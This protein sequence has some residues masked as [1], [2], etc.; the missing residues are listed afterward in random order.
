M[1][2]KTSKWIKIFVESVNYIIIT[3]VVSNMAILLRQN[4]LFIP[5]FA[6]E[7]WV[8]EKYWQRFIRQ[9]EARLLPHVFVRYILLV[10][11]R[12]YCPN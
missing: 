6:S 3:Y 10:Y 12:K 4:W 8:T 9:P 1:K 2:T 5:L 11:C 7:I